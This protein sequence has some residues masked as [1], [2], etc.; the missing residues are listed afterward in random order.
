VRASDK[1]RKVWKKDSIDIRS[2][3]GVSENFRPWTMALGNVLTG[4]PRLARVHEL[5][6]LVW[7]ERC[8][9]AAPSLS[10]DPSVL[11]GPG[12]RSKHAEI[13]LNLAVDVSQSISR[14]IMSKRLGTLTTSTSCYV[15]SLDRLLTGGDNMTLQGWP[16]SFIEPC[17]ESIPPKQLASLAGEAIFVP[18]LSAIVLG[19][20]SL[21]EFGAAVGHPGPSQV[22]SVVAPSQPGAKKPR[23]ET[24]PSPVDDATSSAGSCDEKWSPI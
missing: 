21:P 6:D 14:K 24:P 16:R 23:T 22:V 11:A 2:G 17:V 20:W 9:A 15:F 13:C 19:L 12:G 8:C 5:I 10:V 7:L 3:Y 18:C 4:V 1:Q